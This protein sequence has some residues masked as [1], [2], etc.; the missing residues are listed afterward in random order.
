MSEEGVIAARVPGEASAQGSRLRRIVI[1]LFTVA[2]FLMAT[3]LALGR[4]TLVRAAPPSASG[5]HA[6]FLQNNLVVFGKL[7][8]LGQAYPVIKDVYYVRSEMDPQTKQVANRLVKRGNEWHGPDQ[9]VLNAEHI[10]F[11]EPVGPKSR[12]AELIKGMKAVGQ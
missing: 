2:V 1:V 6:V 11:V 5:Y 12:V 8:K 10:L 4:W 9:M 7:E 3:V